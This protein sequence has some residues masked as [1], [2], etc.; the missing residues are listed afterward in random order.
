MVE[1]EHICGTIKEKTGTVVSVKGRYV[2]WYREPDNY[3]YDD[4]DWDTPMKEDLVGRGYDYDPR[5]SYWVNGGVSIRSVEP[6]VYA[7]WQ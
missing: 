2:D 5:N 1:Q 3:S 6:R 7:P 4:R